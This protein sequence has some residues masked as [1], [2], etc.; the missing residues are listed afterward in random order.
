MLRR[1]ILTSAASLALLSCKQVPKPLAET[2]TPSARPPNI[3]LVLADDLSFSDLSLAGSEIP[4]PNI[5]AL[6]SSGM[7]FTRFYTGPSCA[8]TRAMLMSGEDAHIAGMGVQGGIDYHLP[9]SF[10]GDPSFAGHLLDRIDALPMRLKKL[11]YFT[12]MTG[13]WH[14]GENGGKGAH[15]WGFDRSLEMPHGGASHMDARGYSPKFSQVTLLEDG[16][17]IPFPG[18]FYSTDY[19][20]RQ[21]ISYLHEAGQTGTP[22]FGYVA[23]T[24]PHWPLQAPSSLIDRFEPLYSDGWDKVRQARFD[25]LVDAGFV[26]EGNTLPPRWEGVPEWNTLSSDQRAKEARKMATYAA[27][28]SDLDRSIGTLVDTLKA[29]G[30]YE[31]TIILFL[32]DNGAAAEDFLTLPPDHPRRI[33]IENTY[34]ETSPSG[35]GSADSWSML[36]AGWAQVG[37]VHLSKYKGT[38]YEGGVRAP[39]IISDGRAPSSQE[40]R[41]SIPWY[42]TGI[43]PTLLDWA[44]AGESAT[45]DFLH[46]FPTLSSIL[47]TG[48]SAPIS[49]ASLDSGMVIEGSWKAVFN[50]KTDGT[51][52]WAL[53]NLDSDPS[54]GEDL[55]AQHK[56]ILDSLIEE[57]ENYKKR[58]GVPTLPAG[59]DTTPRP[60]ASMP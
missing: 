1:L 16:I 60:K 15:D 36:G 43:A 55:S 50:T 56:E 57:F 30:L 49:L 4:T 37:S 24:A 58:N 26:R 38:L 20:T 23:Y 39:L 41:I 34:P 32:S 29:E 47:Q 17:P 12:F 8:P 13:K 45:R 52:S 22:F 6:A 53:Y 46:P 48:E 10:Q 59:W 18:D 9:A 44:G 19:Y 40:T 2:D 3:L 51:K 31:N 42:V 35:T 28:V 33:W 54:E 21:A 11:G 7:L 27:M 14:L 5:D 25:G